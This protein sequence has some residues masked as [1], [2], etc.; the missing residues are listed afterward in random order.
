[1]SDPS[2][3]R[4][5]PAGALRRPGPH[6]AAVTVAVG[7]VLTLWNN[8]VHLHPTL[9]GWAFIPANVALA[10]ALLW[11]GRRAGLGWA[12]LGLDRER[13]RGGV[14]LG[15]AWVAVVAV[16]LAVALAVPALRP[17]LEDGRFEGH[18]GLGFVWHAFVRIPLGTALLEEV[19]FRSVFLALLTALVGTG[20]AVAVSSAVFGLW[21]I[22]PGWGMLTANAANAV[23][24]GAVGVGGLAGTVVV[25]GLAGVGFCWLR[26][27]SGSLA[28]PLVAHAGMNGLAT[29]A[30]GVALDAY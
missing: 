23:D 14:A 10:A 3:D 19:A 9:G 28:A 15:A 1:V 8:V 6:L 18:S 7:V 21:H 24:A 2:P 12:A 20:R 16:A 29:L 11:I 26:L 22:R 4:D 25:T 27:R 17:L 30:A 5:A 13:L